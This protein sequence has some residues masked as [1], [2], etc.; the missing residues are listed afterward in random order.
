MGGIGTGS[1]QARFEEVDGG[2]VGSEEQD[3]ALLGG[4][5]IG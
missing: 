4:R 2:V 3:V 5:A 1:F